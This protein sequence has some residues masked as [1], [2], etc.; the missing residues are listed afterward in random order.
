VHLDAQI[1]ADLNAGHCD[2]AADVLHD[3]HH[4]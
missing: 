1:L 3:L 4:L 2:F